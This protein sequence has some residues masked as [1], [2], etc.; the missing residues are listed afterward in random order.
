MQGQAIVQNVRQ[1]RHTIL[2][3]RHHEIVVGRIGPSPADDHDPCASAGLHPDPACDRLVLGT[4]RDDEIGPGALQLAGTT[5]PNARQARHEGRRQEKSTL[6]AR[7]S[8][9]LEGPIQRLRQ[10]Q[11]LGRVAGP[12]RYQ[13]PNV[14]TAGIDMRHQI[15]ARRAGIQQHLDLLFPRQTHDVRHSPGGDA[16]RSPTHETTAWEVAIGTS[17]ANSTCVTVCYRCPDCGALLSQRRR[18]RLQVLEKT[19]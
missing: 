4:G 11:N 10:R 18:Q 13:N 6:S 17:S 5:P 7:E 12:L 14:G 8:L 9:D 1:A 3:C 19:E 2:R 16:T 15:P